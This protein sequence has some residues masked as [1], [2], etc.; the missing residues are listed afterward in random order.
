MTIQFKLGISLGLIGAT[1]CLQLRWRYCQ[2]KPNPRLSAGSATASS[3]GYCS[4][5][6]FEQSASLVTK[7]VTRGARLTTLAADR[8]KV[9]PCGNLRFAFFPLLS[10]KPHLQ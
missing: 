6:Y 7:P 8:L 5:R 2:Q 1:K 3:S 10:V 9:V 4:E